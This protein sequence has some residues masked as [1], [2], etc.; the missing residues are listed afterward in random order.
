MHRIWALV[1]LLNINNNDY[2]RAVWF[3]VCSSASTCQYIN[4]KRHLQI[5]K[6][7]GILFNCVLPY[8][9]YTGENLL[10]GFSKEEAQYRNVYLNNA[11]FKK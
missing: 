10:K 6:K 11:I 2:V 7:I 1:N 9:V 5:Q 3:S 8:K 4:S